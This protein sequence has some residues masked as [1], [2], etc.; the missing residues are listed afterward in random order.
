MMV[1]GCASHRTRLPLLTIYPHRE[2]SKH[3]AHADALY[4]TRIA[5]AHHPRAVPRVFFLGAQY[6]CAPKRPGLECKPICGLTTVHPHSLT[7]PCGFLGSSNISVADA[8]KE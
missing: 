1:P 7:F 4:I 8:N 6:R 2:A 3:T 5:C